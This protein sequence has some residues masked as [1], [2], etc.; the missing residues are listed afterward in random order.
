ML[1]KRHR[2]N[3]RMDG[4]AGGGWQLVYTGFVLI[5]LSLF[6]MLSSFTTFE[7]AKVL[8]F[9]ASFSSAL[10]VL[11]AGISVVDGQRVVPARNEADAFKKEMHLIQ[12]RLHQWAARHQMDHKLEMVLTDETF[13]LRFDNRMLFGTGS[14]ALAVKNLPLLDTVG[15]TIK[16]TDYPV[17]IEGHTDNVPIRSRRYPSNWELSTARAV[18]VLRYLIKHCGIPAH[19]MTA[20]G[21]G[22][23]QPLDGNDAW[24]GRARNRR[25]EII[26]HRGENR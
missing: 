8:Q 15:A 2:P 25:V 24:E 26:L 6:I 17:R 13:T 23:Y 19:R 4:I 18:N 1:L 3:P 16:A 11:P 22:A 20:V 7:Q 12:T 21:C 5:L 14:A 9:V 10:S